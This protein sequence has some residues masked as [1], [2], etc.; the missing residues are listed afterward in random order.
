MNPTIAH[1][2]YQLIE[3]LVMKV[4]DIKKSQIGN[5]ITA[6]QALTGIAKLGLQ[7]SSIA[8]EEAS[9]S[10]SSSTTTTPSSSSSSNQRLKGS[11][12]ELVTRICQSNNDRFVAN[13]IWSLG[14]MGVTDDMM[15]P[16]MKMLL[17]DSASRV[18]SESSSWE[19]CNILWYKDVLSLF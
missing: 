19:L 8:G 11:I 2:S 1:V 15:I 17:I 12:F 14:S 13:A 4:N 5:A 18:M 9:P 16:T 6:S 10:S 3:E 7:W